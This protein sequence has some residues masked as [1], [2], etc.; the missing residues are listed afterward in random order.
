MI[1]TIFTKFS[2]PSEVFNASDGRF[3]TLFFVML[4][5]CF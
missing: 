4:A 2:R 1:I 5:V 3:F